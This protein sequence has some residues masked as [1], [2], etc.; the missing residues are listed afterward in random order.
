MLN[1][2]FTAHK[3]NLNGFVSSNGR[4]PQGSCRSCACVY[5]LFNVT[6]TKAL[7]NHTGDNG[8]KTY[9]CDDKKDDTLVLAT[10]K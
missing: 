8:I 1:R 9:I 7:P 5:C 3:Q 4:H 2:R 6:P 10:P